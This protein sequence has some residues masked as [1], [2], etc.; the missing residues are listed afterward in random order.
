YAPDRDQNTEYAAHRGEKSALGQQLTDDAATARSHGD[1]K[2]HFFLAMR[3]TR[4]HQPGDV[5]ASNQ[6]DEAD[7]NH[8]QIK[9]RRDLMAFAAKR[10]LNRMQMD[11]RIVLFLKQRLGTMNGFVAEDGGR[12]GLCL[13]YQNARLKPGDDDNPK[14]GSIE[15]AI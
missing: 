11:R 14:T 6:Q 13:C 10:S 5:S 1:A 12:S 15:D 9:H 3:R 4:K 8:H 2:C 7:A